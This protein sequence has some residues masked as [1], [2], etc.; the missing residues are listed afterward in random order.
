MLFCNHD[1]SGHYEN[2]NPD[3]Y[4]P[5]GGLLTEKGRVLSGHINLCDGYNGSQAEYVP[6]ANLG[7][8]VIPDSL[9]DDQACS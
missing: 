7:P 9:I 6:Y 2:T 4:G 5:E 1:L 3:H 8:L